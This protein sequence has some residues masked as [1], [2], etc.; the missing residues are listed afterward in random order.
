MLAASARLKI[1]A[2]EEILKSKALKAT[3]ARLKMA[4]P[5]SF[6]SHILTKIGIRSYW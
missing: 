5:G 4:S 6:F 1:M 2:Y 3:S